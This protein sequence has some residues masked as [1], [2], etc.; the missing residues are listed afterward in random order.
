LLA[1]LLAPFKNEKVKA[2]K[3]V[4]E[5]KTKKDK[6]KEESDSSVRVALSQGYQR[7]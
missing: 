6:K 7:I 5:T 1:K 2:E 4:K 3:K